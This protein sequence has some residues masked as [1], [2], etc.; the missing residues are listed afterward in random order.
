MKL[1]NEWKQELTIE[2]YQPFS[3][4]VSLFDLAFY[5]KDNLTYTRYSLDNCEG[6][7][8]EH[9]VIVFD[10]KAYTLDGK[11]FY[12]ENFNSEKYIKSGINVA[13]PLFD[14]RNRPLFLDDSNK[15]DVYD[16]DSIKYENA[17]SINKTL[18]PKYM[19]K[20][21]LNGD[22][23]YSK[24]TSSS[25]AP[26]F[27]IFSKDAC[28]NVSDSEAF[29]KQS[30]VSLTLSFDTMQ[31]SQA[32]IVLC[33]EDTVF[34]N[35]FIKES[36]Y[37]AFNKICLNASNSSFWQIFCNFYGLQ[38]S[39]YSFR[40]F[41]QVNNNIVTEADPAI[42]CLLKH[43]YVLL[44]C[45][46]FADIIDYRDFDQTLNKNA[47]VI[48]NNMI[49]SA[50]GDFNRYNKFS[51]DSDESAAVTRPY[52]PTTTPSI[53]RTAY[54]LVKNF[55]NLEFNS[56]IDKL[57]ENS[58]NP[59]SEI[60]AIPT[61]S[62]EEMVE[63]SDSSF[64][65]QAQ[66]ASAP[67]WFDP[68]SRN[69]AED[70]NDLPIIFKKD[71]NLILDGRIFSRTIDELWEMIKRLVAGRKPDIEKNAEIAYPRGSNDTSTIIST[72]TR[73]SIKHHK[74]NDSGDIGDPVNISYSGSDQLSFTVDEWVNDP[75]FIEYEFLPEFKKLVA[76]D[77]PD[78]ESVTEI[79][80]SIDKVGKPEP[81]T[82][83]YSLREL[84][85]LIRGLQYN[86]ACL[87]TYSNA[88]FVRLGQLH[89]LHNKYKDGVDT[90]IES[91]GVDEVDDSLFY[92]LDNNT[93]QDII[94]PQSVY[95]SANGT[96]QSVS[97]SMRLRIR[98][99]E[100]W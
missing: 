34:E 55:D 14:L 89:Q 21:L 67:I 97:Q 54:S 12:V 44:K 40:N 8:L 69:L 9:S 49:L 81:S 68:D 24:Q 57:I 33:N 92:D 75:A 39:D 87:I 53:D 41:I 93:N 26:G 64:T 23:F 84:E 30:P 17:L 20:A 63:S 35:K 56:Q 11:I 96:W 71:G 4:K 94:N 65:K 2:D 31:D 15:S 85:A 73:P 52:I 66:S 28:M 95:M 80:E 99:D 5:E 32:D 74:L 51:N 45:S 42:I 38:V 88:K 72:D 10:P 48:H 91:Y 78:F 77:Y 7:L 46:F 37:K 60:G 29:N 79:V 82:R 47:K 90:R 50:K 70:Y 98:K 100:E 19:P 43:C 61:Q 16:A 58:V 76:K 22:Y 36:G 59:G 62:F 27:K 25:Y 1:S 18:A 6:L 86:L 83:P 3:M 13:V